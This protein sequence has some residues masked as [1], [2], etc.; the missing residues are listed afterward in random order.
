M[1]EVPL[2]KPSNEKRLS[3]LLDPEEK[4]YAINAIG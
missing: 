1:P 2:M 4:N 3:P